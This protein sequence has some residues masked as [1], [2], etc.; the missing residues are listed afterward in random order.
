[1][2][3]RILEVLSAGEITIEG[4]YANSSNLTLLVSVELD[5]EI[6]KAVHKPEE[7]ERPL[8]DFPGGLW[9][10]EVAAH[11]LD[12]ALGLGMVPLTIGREDGPLGPGSLQRYVDVDPDAHYFTLREDELLEGDLKRLAAFDVV[13]NNS[14]RKS[15]HVLFGDGRLVAIDHGL[16]FHVED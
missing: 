6:V 1:M 14:D 9:R 3:D 4:R 8:W 5:G 13:A 12:E 10:R 7:G 15:G 2:S 11:L 16:S